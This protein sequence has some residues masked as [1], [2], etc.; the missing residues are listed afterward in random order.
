ML[1]PLC[2]TIPQHLMNIQVH[3][4]AKSVRSHRSPQLSISLVSLAPQRLRLWQQS[5]GQNGFLGPAE[6]CLQIVMFLAMWF[7]YFQVYIFHPDGIF[8][9][10][11]YEGMCTNNRKLCY[12]LCIFGCYFFFNAFASTHHLANAFPEICHLPW[13]FVFLVISLET[14]DS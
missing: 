13:R 8:L 3:C 14:M 2:T 9:G 5:V 4:F 1:N 11:R 12:V 10:T 6:H 7:E